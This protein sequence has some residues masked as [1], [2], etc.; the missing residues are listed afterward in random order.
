MKLKLVSA[1]R[2]TR[3]D[4]D[5]LSDIHRQQFFLSVFP[6]QAAKGEDVEEIAYETIETGKKVDETEGPEQF[7]LI[8]VRLE[9]ADKPQEAYEG[10][11][12]DWGRYP[13]TNS[14]PDTGTFFK[15]GTTKSSGVLMSQ[16]GYYAG[17][18]SAKAEELLAAVEEIGNT[19][20][21]VV[22][23]PALK[24][25]PPF[26][27]KTAPKKV[28][29]KKTPSVS[30]NLEVVEAKRFIEAE[31]RK[32]PPM[33][34]FQLLHGL[35]HSQASF[36]TL[37][38][39]DV[40]QGVGVLYDFIDDGYKGDMSSAPGVKRRGLVFLKFRTTEK[41][42]RVF[43][44]WFWDKALYPDK[45]TNIYEGRLFVEGS[46]T[47]VGVIMEKGKLKVAK[48]GGLPDADAITE[49]FK[50]LGFVFEVD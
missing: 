40:W 3:K 25:F 27:K 22:K 29:D 15:A 7:G 50:K 4:L 24:T 32:A 31:M 11:F 38:S 10:W 44:G 20:K 23:G 17:E 6:V 36:Y 47:P 12:L 5:R 33:R 49:A 1:L 26:D 28:P 48:K 14:K 46:V 34:R 37:D 18:K 16:H 39:M 19:F 41:P 2:L 9:N 35:R 30:V 45:K 13:D 42:A 8:Y 21:V 43:E